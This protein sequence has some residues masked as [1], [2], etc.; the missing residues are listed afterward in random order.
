MVWIDCNQLTKFSKPCKN[1]INIQ[2]TKKE[3][4]DGCK[5]GFEGNHVTF[6]MK[7]LML[8]DDDE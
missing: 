6:N 3:V 1:R 5:N 2:N 4:Y 8:D 7:P